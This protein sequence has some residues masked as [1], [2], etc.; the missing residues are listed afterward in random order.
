MYMLECW[1]DVYHVSVDVCMNV[2][3]TCTFECLHGMHECMVCICEYVCVCVCL[4]ESNRSNSKDV[5]VMFVVYVCMHARMHVWMS[6]CTHACMFACC[7][8]PS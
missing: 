5:G 3:R 1:Y 8:Y 2:W 6:V 7:I 4:P